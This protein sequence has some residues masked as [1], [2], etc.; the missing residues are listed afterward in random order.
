MKKTRTQNELAAGKAARRQ[1]LIMGALAFGIGLVMLAMTGEFFS[2]HCVLLI[3]AAIAGGLASA[4]AAKQHDMT[5][6]S[7]K[8]GA[9]VGG[10]Y[11]ALGFGL[12]FAIYFLY[13]WAT[14]TEADVARRLAQLTPAELAQIEAGGITI[15]RDFFIGQ[16]IAY[17]FA[18]VL[19]AL[20]LGWLFG[21][22]GG[23]LA[24]RNA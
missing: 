11:T 23:A 9:S 19:A 12:P 5:P 3:A 4:R 20:I 1:G 13:R 17:V 15:G 22:V 2:L 16:D 7:V 24:Q 14:L 18:Y 21:L 10:I 8:N 6:A